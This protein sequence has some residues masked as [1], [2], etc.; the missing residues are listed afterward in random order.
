MEEVY[1]LLLRRILQAP[2]P[3]PIVSLSRRIIRLLYLAKLVEDEMLGKFFAN[4]WKYPGKDDWVHQV[5]EDLTDFYLKLS[6]NQLRNT[7]INSMKKLG[8]KHMKLPINYRG[9]YFA[10]SWHKRAGKV[11]INLKAP[12][13]FV[14]KKASVELEMG[15]GSHV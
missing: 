15:F 3:A 6:L 10:L 8:K 9:K 4:Q 7:S 2:T 11:S 5:K 12:V 13:E 14:S 1:K